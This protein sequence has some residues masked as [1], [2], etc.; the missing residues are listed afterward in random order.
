MTIVWLQSSTP[1]EGLERTA[2]RSTHGNT[3]VSLTV[4]HAPREGLS[5]VQAR[6]RRQL[7]FTQQALLPQPHPEAGLRLDVLF[8]RHEKKAIA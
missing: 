1:V 6:T 3:H 8:A 7:L 2:C 5:T 4:T